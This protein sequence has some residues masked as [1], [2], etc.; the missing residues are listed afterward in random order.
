MVSI[1]TMPTRLKLLATA[2]AG[3]AVLGAGLGA[4]SAVVG[5]SGGPSENLSAASSVGV[6][7]SMPSDIASSF[8]VARTTRSA[9]DVLPSDSL[10]S[11]LAAGSFAVHYGVNPSLSRLVGT[12]NGVRLWLVPGASGTCMWAEGEGAECGTNA[13]VSNSGFTLV[14]IPVSGAPSSAVGVLPEGASLS[15]SKASGS[16]AAVTTDGSAYYVAA[17]DSAT[18]LAVQTA[19]GDSVNLGTLSEHPTVPGS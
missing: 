9:A 8:A 3:A 5:A 6:A 7:Q 17:Q 11:L 16:P 12:V 10:K 1:P 4:G 14:R 13:S 15:A 19:T 18:S 2:L